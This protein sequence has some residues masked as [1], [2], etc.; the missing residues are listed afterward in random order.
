[1]LID[2]IAEGG[3]GELGVK[4]K[5]HELWIKRGLEDAADDHPSGAQAV[6]RF[7]RWRGPTT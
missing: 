5:L 6:V 2:L 7:V 3:L 1:M 4:S